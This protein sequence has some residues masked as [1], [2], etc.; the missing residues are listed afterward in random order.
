MK[1]HRLGIS[2]RIHILSE[3][4]NLSPADQDL[5][6]EIQYGYSKARTSGDGR[7]ISKVDAQ[8]TALEKRYNKEK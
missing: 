4:E 1:N 8:L 2:E 6:D 3:D 7:R 5:L